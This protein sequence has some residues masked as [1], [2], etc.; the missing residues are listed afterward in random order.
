MNRNRVRF[1]LIGALGLFVWVGSEAGVPSAQVPAETASTP[2]SDGSSPRITG[3]EKAGIYQQFR[4][5]LRE[6]E[7]ALDAEEKSNRKALARMQADRKREWR[8]KERRTRRAYFEAHTSGPERRHYVQDFVRRRK[9][10]D[11][12]EKSEWADLNRKQRDARKELRIS[13]QERTRRV[14]EALNRD[15]KP[16][17]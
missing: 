11:Q 3:A 12:N 13:Q 14:N 1:C 15:Q 7:K 17:L 8:E 10:F 16:E 5:K 2:F 4:N 6:E 9:E